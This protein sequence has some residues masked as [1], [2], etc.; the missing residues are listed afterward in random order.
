ME[1]DAAHLKTS[2]A[3]CRNH[4]TVEIIP[5]PCCAQFH[6]GTMLKKHGG[7]EGHDCNKVG[8]ERQ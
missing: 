4:N 2:P 8:C 1:L 7:Q 5:R 6:L 3:L